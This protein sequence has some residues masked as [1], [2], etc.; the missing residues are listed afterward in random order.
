MATPGVKS[1]HAEQV[2]RSRMA[3]RTCGYCEAPADL[4]LQWNRQRIAVCRTCMGR[5]N[6]PGFACAL[7]GHRPCEDCAA[8]L[9]ARV[10]QEEEVTELVAV[11]EA[12]QS[13][14][15]AVARAVAALTGLFR[16]RR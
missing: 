9:Q 11:V 8:L 1:K 16:P 2:Q 15:S 6:N 4:M 14:R 7:S 3:Q 12:R 13:R 5:L 10:V